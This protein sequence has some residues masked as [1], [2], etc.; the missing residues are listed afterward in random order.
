[1]KVQLMRYFLIFLTGAAAVAFALSVALEA[2]WIGRSPTTPVSVATTAPNAAKATSTV[3]VKQ[4]PKASILAYYFAGP[5]D[6]KVSAGGHVFV[7]D[8]LNDRVVELGRKG[9]QFPSWGSHAIHRARMHHPD[10]V[11][12]LSSG[13]FI[14]DGNNTRVARFSAAGALVS[15][16]TTTGTLGAMTGPTDMALDPG[17][18]LYMADGNNDLVDRLTQSGHVARSWSTKGFLAS[19]QGGPNDPGFPA[20]LAIDHVGKIYVAYP[21]AA[22]VQKFSN[23]GVP[24]DKWQ[25]PERGAAASGVAVDGTGN[26]YVVDTGRAT[27]T[28]FAPS[29]SL[30]TTWGGHGVGKSQ[31]IHPTSIAVDAHGHVY[32]ADAGNSRLGSFIKEWTSN[33]TFVRTYAFG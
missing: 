31:L 33:G 3:V 7:A 15:S 6:V 24:I 2:G 30:L 12:P 9:T 14:I 23:D 25:L 4:T 29:G 18:T 1:M 17:G 27:V 21:N 5:N 11:L 28:K 26:V 22:A 32:V 20:A 16:W 8:T 13:F 19:A 10:R